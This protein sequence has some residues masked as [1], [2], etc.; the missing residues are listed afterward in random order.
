MI[1]A[2]GKPS[3]KNHDNGKCTFDGK[4]SIGEAKE[5]AGAIDSQHCQ[6]QI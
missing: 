4:M 3:T 6:L 1:I 2:V 5:E